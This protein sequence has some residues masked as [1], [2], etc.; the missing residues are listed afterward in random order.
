MTLIRSISFR[1]AV[2]VVFMFVAAV[3]LVSSS[4]ARA[5]TGPLVNTTFDCTPD[6][7][8]VFTNR[9]HAHCNPAAGVFQWF[10]ACSTGSGSAYASRVLSVFTT[11]KVTGKSVR[12]YYDTADTS[13]TACGCNAGDCRVVW[14]A[15]VMP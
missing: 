10:A 15:E 2:V 12:V 14:G 9:V 11:A 3:L 1:V 4:S 5:Q 13:G 7:V 8:G 6:F